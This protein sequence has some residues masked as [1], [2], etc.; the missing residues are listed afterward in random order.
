MDNKRLIFRAEWLGIIL[1]TF[2]LYLQSFHDF[3]I[4]V[5][6][7]IMIV[8]GVLVLAFILGAKLGEGKTK[9]EKLHNKNSGIISNNRLW[10]SIRKLSSLDDGRH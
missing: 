2:G 1:I 3:V 5:M 8:I 6:G 10:N 7:A 9:Y 4:R